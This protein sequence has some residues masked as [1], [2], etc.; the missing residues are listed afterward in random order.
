[1]GPRPRPWSRPRCRPR[2]PVGG[3]ARLGPS[4]RHAHPGAGDRGVDRWRRGPSRR[5]RART[6]V[7]RPARADRAFE[8]DGPGA[9]SFPTAPAA[10][11]PAWLADKLGQPAG[12]PR[13]FAAAKVGTGQMFDRFRL[14]PDRAAGGAAPAPLTPQS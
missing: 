11:T 5:R 4:A 1:M 13:G 8:P 3:R 12:A 14:T 7:R 9:M 10:M 6:I 2:P